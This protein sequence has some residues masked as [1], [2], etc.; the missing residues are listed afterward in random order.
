M[1]LTALHKLAAQW[2]THWRRKYSVTLCK[3]KTEL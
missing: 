1:K 2:I 3:S